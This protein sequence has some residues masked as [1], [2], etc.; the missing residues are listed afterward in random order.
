M[1][2][3]WRDLTGLGSWHGFSRTAVGTTSM[4]SRRM[5]PTETRSSKLPRRPARW[6]AVLPAAPLCVAQFRH[7]AHRTTKEKKC[8][9]DLPV[10]AVASLPGCVQSARCPSAASLAASHRRR[11]FRQWSTGRSE[12]DARR[13]SAQAGVASD[14]CRERSLWL[15]FVGVRLLGR[16]QRGD[17]RCELPG[18]R[19]S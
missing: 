6:Q 5:S 15:R 17:E 11:S 19:R 10:T 8:L 13:A 4:R 14:S 16:G 2:T 9:R 7:L 12:V 1:R 3:G 18:L